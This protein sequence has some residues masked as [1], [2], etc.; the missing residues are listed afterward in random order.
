MAPGVHWTGSGAIPRH[1]ALK[2]E[3][4]VWD[5]YL[6]FGE[7]NPVYR[8]LTKEIMCSKD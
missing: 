5:V 3:V 4:Q 2:R 6:Y 1:V 8:T 7:S